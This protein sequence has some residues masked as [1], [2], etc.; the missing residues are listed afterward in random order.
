[1]TG[2]KLLRPRTLS[3]EDADFVL[4]DRFGDIDIPAQDLLD[5][6]TEVAGI[7]DGRISFL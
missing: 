7:C 1:M 4:V 5:P 6:A 3:T 2:R